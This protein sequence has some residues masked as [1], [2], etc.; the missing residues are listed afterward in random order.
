[1]DE[2]FGFDL[3]QRKTL[4]RLL[5]SGDS[6]LAAL[7]AAVTDLTERVKVLEDA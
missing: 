7:A 2:Y 5:A 3:Q 1:M 4:E 6:G